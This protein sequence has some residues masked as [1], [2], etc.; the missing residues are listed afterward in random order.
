MKKE[1]IF[2]LYML[3]LVACQKGD[4]SQPQLLNNQEQITTVLLNAFDV[5]KPLQ[6]L[7]FAWRDVDGFGGLPPQIDTLK[8][9]ANSQMLFQMILLNELVTPTDTISNEILDKASMHRFFYFPDSTLAHSMQI[10]ATDNDPNNKPLGL[11]FQ[12]V[13]S[14]IDSNQLQIRGNL[15]LILSHYDGIPKTDLPSPE[16]DMDIEFPV[17][18][19]K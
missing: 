18:I 14:S 4:V 12:V 6:P 9:S 16:S 13:C 19:V 8:F 10:R 5:K 11:S 17:T 7:K 3:V 2:S 1:F 15:Q